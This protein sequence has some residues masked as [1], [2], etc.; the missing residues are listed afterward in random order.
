MSKPDELEGAILSAVAYADIFHYPLTAQQIH[1]YLPVFASTLEE[2][3]QVL[4]DSRLVRETLNCQAG[5]YTLAGRQSN[6]ETFHKCSKRSAELW[7][8]AMRYGQILH[9]L[10]FVRMTAVT[11]SLAA[12]NEKGFDLDYLIVTSPGRLWLCRGIVMLLVRWAS[13]SGLVICPNYFIS[14]DSLALADQNLYTAHEIAQMVPISGMDIYWELRRLNPWVAS[15]LPNSSGIPRQ[16]IT[17]RNDVRKGIT[18]RMVEEIMKLPLGAY[19]ESWEMRRKLR[20]FK[21][22]YPESSEAA[23]SP[24]YCKGHFGEYG[25]KSLSAY[26]QKLKELGVSQAPS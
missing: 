25:K 22:I 2:V 7:P 19:V 21:R 26:R 23:F 6:L 15:Y 13:R 20:K 16:D 17:A 11:G 24:E 4:M 5:Y 14:Q 18:K 1:R 8:L 9:Q 12:D 3:Q 10:P